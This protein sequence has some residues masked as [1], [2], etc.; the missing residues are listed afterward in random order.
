MN[1]CL[2]RMA[3][4]VLAGGAYVYGW[5]GETRADV[6]LARDARGRWRLDAALGPANRPLDRQTRTAIMNDVRAAAL[7]AG[8]CR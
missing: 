3:G 6:M 8:G 4:R 5:P 2:D 1:N 7:A